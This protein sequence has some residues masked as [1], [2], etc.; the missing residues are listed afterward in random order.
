MK[1]P[2][3]SDEW[4]LDLILKHKAEQGVHVCVLLF[5]EVGLAL[6]LNSGYSKRA[7]MLL[8][9]NIKVRPPPCLVPPAFSP[10]QVMRHPDHVSSI[11]FLWAHHEKLVVVDQSVAF[12]GGLDLA[13]GRW[14]TPEYRLTDLEGESGQGAKGGGP[15]SGP[16]EE[17]PLDLATNQLL[18]LGKDYGNLIAKDWI[19][20]DKPFEGTGVRVGVD[21]DGQAGTPWAGGRYSL[22]N[23]WD[24][25]DL[26]C[27][28]A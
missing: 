3:Q 22:P 17:A 6:G 16:G 20:L 11:V 23:F 10:C 12:L 28:R 8:H 2:A 4:R 7:L 27:L 1:R 5:K 15:P 21:K 18:W 13:Y 26:L 25:L 14:D 19:Q 9:P 24:L